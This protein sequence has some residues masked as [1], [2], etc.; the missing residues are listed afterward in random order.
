MPGCTAKE[1][2]RP[3]YTQEFNWTAAVPEHTHKLLAW[4]HM[5]CVVMD[6]PGRLSTTHSWLRF[7]ERI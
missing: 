3:V 5:H 2:D 1:N 6:R 7:H 4:L